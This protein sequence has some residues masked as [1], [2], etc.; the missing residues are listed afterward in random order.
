MTARSPA[1][2]RALIPADCASL[3][4]VYDIL[5]RELAL[6]AHFG[7]NLDA[8]HDALTGDV[9]GPF[10]IVVEDAKALERAL[11][12]RGVALI[13]LLREV[14]AARHDAK[15]KLGSAKAR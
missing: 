4:A 12:A 15:I 7:R 13:K 10:A 1:P 3:D 6:P 5:A 2:R 9:A 8:L 11:G 14:A